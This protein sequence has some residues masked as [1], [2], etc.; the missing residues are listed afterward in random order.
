MFLIGFTRDDATREYRHS[1]KERVKFVLIN[2]PIQIASQETT[3][4]ETHYKLHMPVIHK[5]EIPTIVLLRA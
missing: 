4:I 2:P 5:S 3:A 1:T